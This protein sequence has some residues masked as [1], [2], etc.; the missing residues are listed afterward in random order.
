LAWFHAPLLLGGDGI[1]AVAA[2]G[3]GRLAEM[4]RFE[5]VACERLGADV[6]SIFRASFRH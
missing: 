5:P 4:P 6:L 3:L 2:L 1:P